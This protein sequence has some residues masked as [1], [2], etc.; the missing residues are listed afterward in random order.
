[1]AVKLLRTIRLDASDTFVFDTAA[2]SGEWAVPGAFMFWNDDLSSLDGKRR[3]AFRSGFLGVAS[4]GWSTLAIVQEASV[5]EREAAI[6]QL[7]EGLVR[8][9]GA[10]DVA[11]ALP[12]AREE[13]AFAESLCDH[14]PQTL[15][16]VHRRVENGDIREAFR[17]LTPGKPATEVRAFSFVSVEGEDAP[18]DG[19]DL[20]AMAE[21]R[22]T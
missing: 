2:A 19:V 16:A 7:A 1:M 11:T 6:L 10:P 18:Q 20:A 12:A 5:A 17:T 9:C 15:V 8:H 13:M 3:S 22:R 14:P 4:F 21:G